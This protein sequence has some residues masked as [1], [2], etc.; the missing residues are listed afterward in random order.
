MIVNHR[1]EDYINS[2][3]GDLPIHLQE[4]AKIS[5][6]NEIP[7]IKKETGTLLRFLI[8]LLEP[9]K[10]LEVGTATGFSAIFMSEYMA[11]DSTITT[12]EK[13]ESR[14]EQA[15]INLSTS[16]KGDKITLLEG[17]A[18]IILE[19]LAKDKENDFDF[20]FL[21]SAKG[22]Y[23]NFLPNILKILGNGG[24]LITDNVLQDGDIAGSRYA[25]RR[26]DRTIHSRMREYLY[27]LTH[28][29]ELET[30]ILPIGD[31]VTLSTKKK[32]ID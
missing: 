7:I 17:D 2:L 32:G 19:D 24:I 27:T 16:P 9:E 8:K 15:R 31:G 10:I 21:D 29:E 28:S 30:V 4:L 23:I 20:I 6:N 26:R 13:S 14:L 1:V 22:Q 12:I 3:E 11:E 25:I 5:I 18:A